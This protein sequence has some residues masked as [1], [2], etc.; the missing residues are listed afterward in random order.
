MNN[1]IKS[2]RLS[3]Q[4][5]YILGSIGYIFYLTSLIEYNLVQIVSAEKYLKVFD[6]DDISFIDIVSAKE[7]SNNT[8]HELA[9]SNVMLGS[10]ISLLEKTDFVEESF[11]LDLRKVATIRGYYAHRFFKEDL[12]KKH[13]E[14]N[15]LVYKQ[16]IRKDI[17]FIFSVH[18]T[19]FA[20]E[21]QER[22]VALKAK[23]LGL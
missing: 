20:I 22:Y 23:E 5:E 13:L 18:E 4:L 16:K 10:L 9:N 7:E 12:F 2:K 17:S 14:K 1:R 3:K 21:Q 11:I 15:P 19:V 8:L 6:K